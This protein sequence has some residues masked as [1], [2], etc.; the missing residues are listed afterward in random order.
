[1]SEPQA[2]LILAVDDEPLVLELIMAAL[3][4]GGYAVATARSGAEG[5]AVLDGRIAELGGLI[6]DVNLGRGGLS[7]WDVGRHGRELN[8]DLPV[9]YVSGDSGHDWAAHGVPHSVLLQKPFAPADLVVALA[10]L[11]KTD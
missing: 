9:V 1:V 11:R 7:G 6:T 4:D 2:V 10:G 5:I 8:P 3:E